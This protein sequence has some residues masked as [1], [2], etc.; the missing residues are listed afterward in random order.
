M[1]QV[2][3]MNMMNDLLGDYLDRFVLVFLDDI[4]I[5]SANIDQ[6]VEHLRQVLQ[7]LREHRLFAK[8][9]KCEF[10]KTTIEFL[11][12]QVCGD[13]LTP[14]EA[15][16]KAIRDW[17][18]PQNVIDV[19]SFLGFTNYYRRFIRNYSDIVGPLTD[20]TKK[21]MVWQWGPF[22]RNAFEAIK[23]AFCQAP[24]L[25]FPDPKL[26]YTIVTDASGTGAGGSLLQDQGDG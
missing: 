18:T 10:V 15:K 11:G 8:A 3:F 6:H 23:E 7:R 2:Q 12:Q 25:I 13:G 19:R 1:P 20:L 22:Q 17:A 14:T 21:D 26:Q 9:S 24:I 4:L 5:Y 16:L